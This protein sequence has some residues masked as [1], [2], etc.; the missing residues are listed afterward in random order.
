[1][2]TL[3][4]VSHPE[5]KAVSTLPVTLSFD[6]LLNREDISESLNRNHLSVWCKYFGFCLCCCHPVTKPSSCLTTGCVL[7]LH[8][9]LCWFCLVSSVLTE[10]KAWC[11]AAPRRLPSL[12]HTDYSSNP[13][14]LTAFKQEEWTSSF[15]QQTLPI[16]SFVSSLVIL[17]LFFLRPHDWQAYTPCRTSSLSPAD[18]V[19]RP[20]CGRTCFMFYVEKEP[21]QAPHNH[22]KKKTSRTFFN[23]CLQTL[24]SFRSSICKTFMSHSSVSVLRES[25][26]QNKPPKTTC[27]GGRTPSCRDVLTQLWFL[28]KHRG[29]KN[30]PGVRW[31]QKPA[32]DGP[33]SAGLLLHYRHW[34][35][36]TAASPGPP[37]SSSCF[38]RVMMRSGDVWWKEE[39]K[40]LKRQRHQH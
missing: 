5:Y 10:I 6:F 36:S 4:K 17:F 15:S 28:H 11:W 40:D 3:T 8:E 14:G 2:L 20:T 35:V 25:P 34:C 1:M 19:F 24:L 18:C 39:M 26:L 21:P 30:L 27:W 22:K 29:A 37:E 23:W 13:V 31:R 32:E 9:P 7:I 38:Y 16:T 33:S 12:L